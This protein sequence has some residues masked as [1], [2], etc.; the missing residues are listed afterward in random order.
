M[1]KRQSQ[2]EKKSKLLSLDGWNFCKCW[3]FALSIKTNR[4]EFFI[5]RLHHLLDCIDTGILTYLLIWCRQS[6]VT[7]NFRTILRCTVFLS[8]RSKSSE[9]HFLHRGSDLLWT[10]LIPKK[11]RSASPVLF[12]RLS[13]TEK[14][15]R[16]DWRMS[17]HS[18]RRLLAFQYRWRFVETPPGSLS[19][20]S[21]RRL[22]SSEN[23]RFLRASEWDVRSGNKI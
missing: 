23:H 1:L 16:A 17:L 15:G 22:E 14:T 3:I 4:S 11:G 8:E 10:W 7:I 21:F 5:L 2:T 18:E 19:I 12:L 9:P 13:H 6:K 20:L